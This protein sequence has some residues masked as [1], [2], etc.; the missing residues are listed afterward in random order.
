MCKTSEFSFESMRCHRRCHLHICH[1]WTSPSKR[2]DKLTNVRGFLKQ[3]IVWI[4][5]LLTY[6]TVLIG[7]SAPHEK[8]SPSLLLT[9]TDGENSG[10]SSGRRIT[11]GTDGS[12]DTAQQ[13]A[14]SLSQSGKYSRW[15]SIWGTQWRAGNTVT[16][17]KIPFFFLKSKARPAVA[18]C[19]CFMW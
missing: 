2:W 7:S 16:H 17:Q 13:K 12:R 15:S 4:K 14:A 6:F 8:S 19:Q 9:S 11:A 3:R 10:R 5:Y 18:L 1:G